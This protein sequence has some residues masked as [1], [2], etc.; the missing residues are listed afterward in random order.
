L[1]RETFLQVVG[2]EISSPKKSSG[3]RK[4]FADCAHRGGDAHARA[5]FGATKV[6]ARA[7]FQAIG[8]QG[9]L[10]IETLTALERTLVRSHLLSWREKLAVLLWKKL[11]W[12]NY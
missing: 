10:Q 3:Q 4:T 5:M 12:R 9:W 8:S 2:F 1:R 11:V 6:S 7:R